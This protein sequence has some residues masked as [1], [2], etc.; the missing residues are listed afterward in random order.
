MNS[1]FSTTTGHRS[2]ISEQASIG[3]ADTTN[4]QKGVNYR[5]DFDQGLTEEE[6]KE[7]KRFD[8]YR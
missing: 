4:L 5:E 7:L 2:P 8:I 1:R 3:I 6:K